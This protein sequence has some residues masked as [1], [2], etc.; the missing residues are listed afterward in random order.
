MDRDGVCRTGSGLSELEVVAIKWDLAR[1]NLVYQ[2]MTK[3]SWNF[4]ESNQKWLVLDCI[5]QLVT[6]NDFSWLD[7][8]QKELEVDCMVSETT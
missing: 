7:E 6:E 5:S 2:N 4:L 8:G 3:T 1:T